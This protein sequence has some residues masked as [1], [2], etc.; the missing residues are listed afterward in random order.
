MKRNAGDEK[1]W[2]ASQY[3]GILRIFTSMKH[4]YV[5]IITEVKVQVKNLMFWQTTQQ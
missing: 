2:D 5:L 3:A 1:H 4:W